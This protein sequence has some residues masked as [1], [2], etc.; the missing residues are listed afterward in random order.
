MA[1]VSWDSKGDLLT[2]F[3]NLGITITADVYCE[4]LKKL[5]KS[6]E[7]SDRDCSHGKLFF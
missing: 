7:T 3:M 6:I 2:E 5:Q 1:I 4:T